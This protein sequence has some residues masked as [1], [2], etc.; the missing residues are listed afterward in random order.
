MQLKLEVEDQ[1]GAED[2]V[3]VGVGVECLPV[4]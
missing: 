3:G 2:E 1:V 4:A